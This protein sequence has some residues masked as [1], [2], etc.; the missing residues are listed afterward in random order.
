MRLP[1]PRLELEAQ[2][3]TPPAASLRLTGSPIGQKTMTTITP[4]SHLPTLNS[5][6]IE[7]LR[8]SEIPTRHSVYGMILRAEQDA[9]ERQAGE[10][11]ISAR[12]AGY[13]LLEFH[14]QS[15]LFGDRACASIVKQVTSLL[16]DASGDENSVIFEVGR[17]LRDKFIRLCAFDRL[18]QVTLHSRLFWSSGIHCLVSP[19]L[20]PPFA[21]FLRQAG[22]YDQGLNGGHWQR[23]QDR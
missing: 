5:P 18:S 13:L 11:I 12:V 21:P 17:L 8:L 19:S 22:R 3:S 1:I 10:N 14:A 20:H 16:Q 23:L 6:Q 2:L 4:S 15:R 7:K 9:V